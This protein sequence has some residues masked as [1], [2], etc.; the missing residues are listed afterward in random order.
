MRR[1]WKTSSYFAHRA[2]VAISRELSSREEG[3]QHE[4][5]WAEQVWGLVE[6]REGAERAGGLVD[7]HCFLLRWIHWHCFS[8][9]SVP[10]DVEGV[11]DIT[12]WKPNLPLICLCSDSQHLL[13]LW[14]VGFAFL[15]VAYFSGIYTSC[16]S[17]TLNKRS[18]GQAWTLDKMTYF[19][20]WVGKRYEA[21]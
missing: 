1:R 21:S 6:S 17:H 4:W 2:A 16:L 12:E 13:P 15:H 9:F 3:I 7:F 11:T 10:C 14:L 5:G 8:V 18:F 19:D 20:H